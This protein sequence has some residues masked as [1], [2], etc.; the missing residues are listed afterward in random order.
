MKHLILMLEYDEDDKYITLQ[1]FQDHMSRIEV[2]IVA[3][4]ED[5]IAYLD[6]C[7]QGKENFPSMLLLNFNS[8]PMN[9]VELIAEVKSDPALRH[10]PAVVLSGTVITGIVRECYAHGASS[11]IRKPST[12]EET[13]K[14]INSFI[15]YWFQTVE[16]A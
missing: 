16:L 12:T 15:E 3:S 13:T 6:A 11:F 10:I 9:A 5:V 2:K 4:S 7:K 1:Y 8:T 14:K